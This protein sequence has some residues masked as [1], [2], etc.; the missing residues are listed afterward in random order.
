MAKAQLRRIVLS[1]AL[2]AIAVILVVGPML[3]RRR[4]RVAEVEAASHPEGRPTA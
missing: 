1:A 2:L 3:F 4:Q